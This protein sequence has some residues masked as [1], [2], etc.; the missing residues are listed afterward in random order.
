MS[1]W[2]VTGRYHS[3]KVR[4][5]ALE[6]ILRKREGFK[7]LRWRVEYR[8]GP[9]PKENSMKLYRTITST[10]DPK[11]AW[12]GSQAEAASQRKA[13]NQSGVRRDDIVTVE[14]DVPTDKKGLLE[15]LNKRGGNVA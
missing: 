10:A 1:D 7:G 4:D 11:E 13:F 15:F 3:E 5:T 9:P 14:V 12:A 2:Y 8:A 6:G